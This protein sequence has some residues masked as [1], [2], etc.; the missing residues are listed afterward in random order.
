MLWSA[1]THPGGMGELPQEAEPF[2]WTTLSYTGSKRVKKK[3]KSV[4]DYCIV[5]GMFS[6]Q[7]HHQGGRDE[8]A[9]ITG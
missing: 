6:L 9:V 4:R 3:S 2:H 7:Y 5:S 1:Y 8:E